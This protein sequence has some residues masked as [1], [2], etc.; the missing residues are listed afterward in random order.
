LKSRSTKVADAVAKKGK[1][2][3]G[4]LNWSTEAFA[5]T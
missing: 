4:E 3:P 5:M 2:L 1:W